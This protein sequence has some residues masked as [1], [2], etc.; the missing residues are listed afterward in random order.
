MSD[1]QRRLFDVD[2]EPWEVDAQSDEMVA[3]VL[4]PDR[5]IGELDYAVPD[6]LRDQ[7]VPGRRVRF[8]AGLIRSTSALPASISTPA[9]A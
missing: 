4:L 6:A 7:V 3:V 1:A 8:A 5:P 2:A 9:C